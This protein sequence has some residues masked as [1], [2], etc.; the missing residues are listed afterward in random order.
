MR[1]LL[2]LDSFNLQLVDD[3][4]PLKTQVAQLHVLCLLLLYQSVVLLP[5][6]MNGIYLL[7]QVVLEAMV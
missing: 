6:V 7:P 2:L 1:L 4:F 5:Q 3:V